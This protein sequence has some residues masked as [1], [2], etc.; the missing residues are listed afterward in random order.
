MKKI[1]A[2]AII[3][4]FAAGTF[5]HGRGLSRAEFVEDINVL[6]LKGDYKGLI[7]KQQGN[8]RPYR[9]GIR[10]K[11]EIL[12]FAGL[13]FIKLGDFPEA[14][15]SFCKVLNMRGSEF[16]EDS[17]IGIADSYLKEK[18]FDK[19]IEEYEALLAMYPGSSRLSSIYYNLGLCYEGKNNPGKAN[20]Y[21]QKLKN[22]YETSFE[23]DKISYSSL[24]KDEPG[25]YIIQLGA[26]KGIRNAKKLVR[27]LARK[28][29]DSYIQKVRKNGSVLYRVRGGK[30]SNRSY[31]IRL[32]RKL[33]KHGFAAKII[34]E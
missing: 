4:L 29:Y 9:L 18:R 10:D 3:S 13:S 21:F 22:R 14:R 2:F 5:S 30:F 26:F 33:K 8:L 16:N 27:K 19:A 23:A 34:E 1:I 32:L 6:F 25:F 12:Y 20:S 11:K 28:K 17:H 7:E 24:E 15:E 31:A